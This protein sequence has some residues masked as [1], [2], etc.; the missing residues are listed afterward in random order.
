[1]TDSD[2]DTHVDTDKYQ[3]AKLALAEM[4]A[5]CKHTGK[6]LTI[7][8]VAKKAKVDRKYFYGEI[9]TP[10]EEL[11]ARW[12]S[13]G[14]QIQAFRKNQRDNP[15]T[16][17]PEKALK[18]KEFEQ[19][20]NNALRENYELLENTQHSKSL[21]A[22]LTDQ[23]DQALNTIDELKGHVFQLES[24]R[25]SKPSPPGGQSKVIGLNARTT[26]ISPDALCESDGTLARKKAWIK[27]LDQLRQALSRPVESDLFLTIGIPGSGKSHWASRFKSDSSRPAIVFDA[28]NLTRVDR[29]DILDIARKGSN[30]RLIAVCFLTDLEVAINRNSQ[31]P[32]A[33]RVP[34]E[35]IKEMLKKL[36]LPEIDDQE[37]RFDQIMIFREGAAHE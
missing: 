8:G 37:E 26:L 12:K 34:Q 4:K 22:R 25:R 28:T 15:D 24:E 17:T 9:N 27:A 13:L 2:V 10:N 21:I 36:E 16:R 32:I 18:L 20:L 14:E 1:M 6:A 31:R 35:K 3:A 5:E 29:Y 30:T 33:L 7:S 23:R 19:N 11:K